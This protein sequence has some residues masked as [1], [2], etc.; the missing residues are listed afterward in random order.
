LVRG[1]M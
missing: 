1:R